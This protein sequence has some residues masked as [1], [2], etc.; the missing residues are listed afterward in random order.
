MENLTETVINPVRLR[1]IQYLVSHETASTS[2]ISDFLHDVPK[3]SLYRHIKRLIEADLIELAEER[4]VRG[5]VEKIYRLKKQTAQAVDLTEMRE[6][7][8]LLFLNLMET[9]EQ[10]FAAGHDEQDM[11][12]DMLFIS[13]STYM[14]SDEEFSEFMAELSDC[15]K[16]RLD[17]EASP[18]RKPRHI[19]MI[20]APTEL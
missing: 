17:N 12:T 7:I 13:T 1:I 16:K 20:S 6:Q 14:M 19:Y 4:R 3:P 10:Y 8:S 18:Q 15:V 11:V 5:T 2:Q 9:F